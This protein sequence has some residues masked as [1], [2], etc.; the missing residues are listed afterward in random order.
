VNQ[1]IEPKLLFGVTAPLFAWVA[2]GILL[3]LAAF[4]IV[5]LLIKIRILCVSCNK[6]SKSLTDTRKPTLGTGLSLS[7]VEEIRGHF[8]NRSN[9]VSVWTQ[10]EHKLIRRQGGSGDEYWLSVPASEVLHSSAV[11]DSQLNREWYEAIPGLLS[12][13][14]LLVTFIAI[15]VALLHVRLVGNRVEGMA[16]LIEGLSGKFVSS[17]AALFAATLFVMI[18]KPQFHRLDRSISRLADAVADVVPVLTPTHLL[19]EL[20][21]D[22]GE[23]SVAFRTFNADLSGRLKQSFSESV[24]PTLERMVTAVEDLNQLLRAAETAKSDTISESLAGM[25][26]RLEGSL[27]ESLCKMGE[28]FTSSLSGS[29]MTQFSRLTDSL[30]GAAGVLEQMNTQNQAT[31]TALTELVNFAKNSTAEQMAL[32]RT[33]VED[34]TNVLRSML[35]QI[36]QATGSSVNNMGAA[37][38]ALMADLSSKVVELNEQ[39]RSAM[40]QTTQASTD[41]AKSVLKD[42][43]DWSTT[44]KEQL[45]ALIEKHTSQLSTADRLR[46]SLDQSA[47]QFIGA[48]SQFNSILTKLQQVS[49]DAATCTTAMSGA[50]KSVKDSQDGLQ[51]VAGL[52][53][54][55]VDKLSMAGREQQELLERIAQAMTQ[56]QQTFVKVESSASALLQTLE[57]NLGQHLELC[58]RGYESLIKVSDEHFTSAT[59]RLGASVDELSEYLQDLS[60]VMAARASGKV[61]HG[62]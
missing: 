44:S 38:T 7:D 16:L 33:Q 39:T 4:S 3:L 26:S 29:T 42:A 47:T 32:G 43:S 11:T 15:L 56:Y 51:R 25:I 55:Q 37:L 60:D 41:A 31:Q 9:L 49:T 35:V 34:L 59:Q 57:R 24:G 28:Q 22:I 58:K 17:I 18:E 2:A 19:V 20:Q 48:A 45:A 14:G 6:L 36:E 23:Q 62:N 61:G 10:I 13:T 5:T 52:S 46:E 12:G 53:S 27:T 30:A 8:G 54:S 21:K 40:V 50:A 1:L